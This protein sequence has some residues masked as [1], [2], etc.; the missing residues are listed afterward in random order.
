MFLSRRS[1]A[2]PACLAVLAAVFLA[3]LAGIRPA[4]AAWAPAGNPL[5]SGFQSISQQ[6]AAATDDAGGAFVLW[7]ARDSMGAGEIRAIHV[8]IDGTLAPG[9]PANGRRICDAPMLA[10]VD[11]APDGAGGLYLSITNAF[12]SGTHELYAQRMRLDGTLA[13]GWTA[14]G[15]TISTSPGAKNV[16][17]RSDGLGGAGLFWQ[18]RTAGAPFGPIH[19][20]FFATRLTG[21]GNV[22]TGWPAGG[23][24]VKVWPESLKVVRQ[25]PQFMIAD[26]TGGFFVA[27]SDSSNEVSYDLYVQRLTA[28]GAIAYGWPPG[29]RTVCAIL[30]EK[31]AASYLSESPALVTD[32]ADGVLVAWNELRGGRYSGYAMRID[33]QGEDAPGW[34][35]DAIAPY[36]DGFADGFFG[37]RADG[38]GGAW[39]GRQ[40]YAPDYTERIRVGHINPYGSPDPGWPT[41]GVVVSDTMG[42]H[43]GFWIG[44]DGADGARVLWGA[45]PYY[46]FDRWT[47]VNRVTAAGTIA[48]GWPATGKPVTPTTAS[49]SGTRVVPDQRGGEIVL[50]L[51]TQSAPYEI[52]GQR[53]GA[54]GDATTDAPRPREARMELAASPNPFSANVGFA[55]TLPRPGPCAVTVH[56]IAGREVRTL[57]RG[58]LG[59]GPQRFTWDGRSDAGAAQPPGI[60]MVSVRAPG[61]EASRRIVRVR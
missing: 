35:P 14:S 57:A 6:F 8:R 1:N 60:Y 42:P 13:A 11:A 48:P 33:G 30:S 25:R 7:S 3:V 58:E 18:E 27:W 40:V 29:G 53:L 32:G 23:L 49:R 37:L 12:L 15:L 5:T 26:G 50:W 39:L 46:Y 20:D 51:D 16:I 45:D 34:P 19:T 17:T 36:D 24:P 28:T 2:T 38:A 56:D 10:T 4:Q 59:A 43:T 61:F 44:S 41:G 31:N 22:A 9:W 21:T 55:L 47:F 54:D 52:W